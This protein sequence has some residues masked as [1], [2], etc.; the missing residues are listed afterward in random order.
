MICTSEVPGLACL[1]VSIHIVA[2]TAVS[3]DPYRLVTARCCR[4][5]NFAPRR[6]SGCRRVGVIAH[7]MQV[8]Q[9]KQVAQQV[10]AKRQAYGRV[11][12]VRR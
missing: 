11:D 3:L 5:D 7:C 2:K 1:G 4:N 12:K 8:E 6:V 9:Q 10:Q